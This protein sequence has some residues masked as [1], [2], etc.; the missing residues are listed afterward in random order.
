MSGHA[1]PKKKVS[2]MKRLWGMSIDLDKCTGCGACQ[3]ACSQENNMPIFDDDSDLPKRVVFL[4]LM[5]VTN[6]N[7]RDAKFGEVK[8][9]YLPKMCM[10]CAGNDPENP[11][12]PCVSVCPVVAT[13]VGDDG[14]VS[15]IWSRCIGCRYCQASCPYE[16]RVFHWWK[17][18]YEGS[19]QEGLNPD[20]SVSSRG[21]VVKCTFCS[22]IWKRERDKMIA[23]GI[24]DINAVQYTPAC[25][26]SC[27][28]G[29]M[30]FGDL[31]DPQS[32]VYEE[33]LRRD[34]RAVRLVHSIDALRDTNPAEYERRMKIKDF[35]NPKVWYLTSNEWLREKLSGFKKS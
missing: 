33:K 19:F 16:A 30:K 8:V 22:H 15:Q 4:D 20:V 9:A 29:A 13:D 6:E 11:H 5:K 10:Q 25:V 32:P 26:S 21:A 3:V 23:K 24:T 28:T 1:A 17:P 14:V 7:D 2:D 31:K 27:P 18:R 34:P 12:P 35:P